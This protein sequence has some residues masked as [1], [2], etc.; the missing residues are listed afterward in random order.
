[1]TKYEVLNQLN[2]KKIK[3]KGDLK[4][5]F[6]KKSQKKI[7]KN[8]SKNSNPEIKAF[9]KKTIFFFCFSYF[10]FAHYHFRARSNV[11]KNYMYWCLCTKKLVHSIPIRFG[12]IQF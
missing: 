1:M 5:N 7:L 9:K 6:S 4:R 2:Q 11:G 12:P 3:S 8:E 10:Y